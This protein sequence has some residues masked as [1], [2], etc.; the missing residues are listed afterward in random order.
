VGK[1]EP[2]PALSGAGKF[3]EGIVAMRFWG[4]FWVS[5]AALPLMC[6]SVT[7]QQLTIPAPI[8]GYPTNPLGPGIVGPQGESVLTRPG[9]YAP[10]G[11]RA[12]SFIIHPS[13]GVS[14]TYDSNI[15]ATPT[16]DI[17]DFYVTEAPAVTVDSDWSR[18]S[19]SL[20]AAGQFKQYISHSTEDVN[21]GVADARGK[22]DI[23]AGQY[24][25]GDAGYSLQHEDRSAP[26]SPVNAQNPVEYHVTGAYLAYVRE[27]AR[28]GLR[29]D[30]T[31]TSYSYNN[32]S[33][34]AGATIIE[35]DR[36]RIEYVVAPRVSY[37]FS[38]GY[39]AFVRAVG[40]VRQYNSVDQGALA[41]VGTSSRRNSLGYEADVGAAVEITHL[42][43][44]QI[45]VGWLHQEFESPLFPNA[46]SPAFG[47]A[48][49]WNVTPL[50]SIRGSFSRTVAE[51]TLFPASSSVETALSLSIE[52]QL[53][54]NLILVG[55]GQV[56]RDE[57]DGLNRT[58]NT[59]GVAAGARYLMNRN[60]R[61]TAD[62][63]FSNRSSNVPGNNYDRIVGVVG[64]QF[65]F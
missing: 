19:V 22:L 42:I 21:N 53:L 29:V 58:D 14:G 40:N 41:A 15:F 25:L 20:T 5:T 39:Q 61:L 10:L 31:V 52:H 62:L 13:L 6:G 1:A 34:G 55:T 36:D 16:R 49:L 17:G 28:I 27:L 47:G 18:H 60:V 56:I 54:R 37:E 50:D 32:A 2:A 64:A 63:D 7:A 33:T 35:H 11:I 65:G 26:T 24:L 3:S 46:N 9:D 51:T 38:P 59:F 48:L 44:A 45:F 30:S 12:G 43:S 4:A 23:S 57:Y 8:P